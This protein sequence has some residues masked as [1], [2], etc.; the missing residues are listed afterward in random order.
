[1]SL[2]YP[3]YHFCNL[4]SVDN[5]RPSAELFSIPASPEQL[6]YSHVQWPWQSTPAQ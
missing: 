6:L 1:V 2:I 4:E 5:A 3:G